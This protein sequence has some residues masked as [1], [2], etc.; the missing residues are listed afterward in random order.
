MA[1]HGICGCKRKVFCIVICMT[2]AFIQ[3]LIVCHV[4]HFHHTFGW[5]V[6][7]RDVNIGDNAHYSIFLIGAVCHTTATPS[8]EKRNT[9]SDLFSTH[10]N[11]FIYCVFRHI[12]TFSLLFKS[13]FSYLSWTHSFVPRSLPPFLVSLHLL[14]SLLLWL[15]LILCLMFPHKNPGQVHASLSSC[16]DFCINIIIDKKTLFYKLEEVCSPFRRLITHCTHISFP[17]CERVHHQKH[18]NDAISNT[19]SL[20]TR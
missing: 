15:L 7:R 3:V 16:D 9:Y 19:D 6:L 20:K 4:N 17:F 10:S 1:W 5:F 13:P 12:H 18:N 11:L 2:S 14:T 8:Q